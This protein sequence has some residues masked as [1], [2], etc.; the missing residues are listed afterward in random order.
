MR[1]EYR[2]AGGLVRDRRGPASLFAGD[3][4]AGQLSIKVYWYCKSGWWCCGWQIAY[5]Y[6]CPYECD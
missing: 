4:V 5:Q 1:F 3:D 2:G 6:G